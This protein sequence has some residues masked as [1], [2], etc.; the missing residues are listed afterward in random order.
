MKTLQMTFDEA[1]LV[2]VDKAVRRLKTSR[3]A[4]A[5]EALRRALRELRVKDL[6]ERHRRGYAS[7]P[8]ADSEF[9]VWEDEQK[10]GEP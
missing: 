8:V 4:F 9:A 5:R 1:L 10:W 2:E 6:E 3:S 7:A